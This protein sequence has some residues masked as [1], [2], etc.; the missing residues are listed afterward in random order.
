MQNCL[1]T[2]KRKKHGAVL[3]LL[4]AALLL[5]SAST[6]GLGGLST[7]TMFEDLEGNKH[8]SSAF[9]DLPKDI[10]DAD[11]DAEAEKGKMNNENSK[12]AKSPQSTLDGNLGDRDFSCVV[13]KNGK[14]IEKMSLEDYVTGCVLGEMPSGF[15]LEALMA[16]S[17]AVRT[18]AVRGM[19]GFSKHKDADICTDYRCCQSY[20][21]PDKVSKE[22]LDK[23]KSAVNATRGIIAT[24]EGEPIVAVYHSSSG[25][26][27]LSSK[28]VWGGDLPYLVSTPSPEGETAVSAFGN[29]H[30]V[31]MSQHGAN[32]LAKEGKTFSDILKYYYKGIN[33]SFVKTM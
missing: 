3:L 7:G 10:N 20:H 2:K 4:A 1:Q 33:L 31:G 5:I 12:N 23:V 19:C 30:R 14:G 32:L 21:N 15:E 11:F 22:T 27:T 29:G 9:S 25:E 18:F 6:A 26:S 16:Q 24:Y 17:I 28:E 8:L 13:V